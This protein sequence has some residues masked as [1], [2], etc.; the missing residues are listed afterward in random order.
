ML[1]INGMNRDFFFPSN[2]IFDFL[3]IE[4]IQKKRKLLEQPI[5]R[6]TSQGIHLFV[7]F[8]CF[9]NGLRFVTLFEKLWIKIHIN[10]FVD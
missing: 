7:Y 9:L 1:I 10:L 4:K 6:L 5:C 8:I 3:M 2:L